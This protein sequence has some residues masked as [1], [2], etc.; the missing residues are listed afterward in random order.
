MKTWTL[1]LVITTTTTTK[2][3]KAHWFHHVMLT[4][5]DGV[6]LTYLKKEAQ[7]LRWWFISLM[8]CLEEISFPSEEFLIQTAADRQKNKTFWE[9]L[10]HWKEEKSKKRHQP[11]RKREISTNVYFYSTYIHNNMEME[12]RKRFY[13]WERKCFKGRR[14]RRN[15]KW[16]NKEKNG[17]GGRVRYKIDSISIQSQGGFSI[18][19]L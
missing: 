8:S 14:W 15:Q 11:K 9:H 3:K 7:H 2:A 13:E 17:T 10:W 6:S 5:S 4:F 19:Y 18:L 12:T 16:F 1:Q